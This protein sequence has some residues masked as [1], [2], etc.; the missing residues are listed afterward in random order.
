MNKIHKIKENG[1]ISIVIKNDESLKE[2]ELW[3]SEEEN[4]WI[5][6]GIE[7]FMIWN[8][9]YKETYKSTEDVIQFIKEI[10]ENGGKVEYIICA[11]HFYGF[12]KGELTGITCEQSSKYGCSFRL[13]SP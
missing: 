7:F 11:S 9:E 13:P 8:E 5:H 1:L 10:K 4:I 6:A 12:C 2:G 3:F